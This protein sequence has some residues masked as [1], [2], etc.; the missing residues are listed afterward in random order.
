MT[1]DHLND[2]YT[3]KYV[4]KETLVRLKRLQDTETIEQPQQSFLANETELTQIVKSKGELKSD[5]VLK[6]TQ[7]GSS[8][9]DDKIDDE[10]FSSFYT[11][12]K[13][14]KGLKNGYADRLY[15]RSVST[16]RKLPLL[17]H[18]L[19]EATACSPPLAHT[20]VASIDSNDLFDAS[21]GLYEEIPRSAEVTVLSEIL[22]GYHS[23]EAPTI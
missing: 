17:R 20:E 15:L 7:N 18:E 2:L 3:N 13:S 6:S 4:K 1:S 11:L 10:G 14:S 12:D 9:R 23:E 5:R 21:S 16:L 8:K 22:D 19:L